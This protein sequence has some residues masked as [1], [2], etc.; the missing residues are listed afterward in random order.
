MARLVFF[1]IGLFVVEFNAEIE[2]A[3]DTCLN[4]SRKINAVNSEF[5][6]IKYVFLTYYF[7][8]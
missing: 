8:I 5:R 1:L 6:R 3:I 2:E 7:V 4:S